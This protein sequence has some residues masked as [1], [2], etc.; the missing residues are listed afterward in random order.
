MSEIN[1]YAIVVLAA[2]TSSRLGRPK[3]LLNIRGT[4][5]LHYIV[6]T[7]L[8]SN[9]FK[10]LVVVGS[11]AGLMRAE[12]EDTD[13]VV[14]TNPEYEEGIASSIRVGISTME[15]EEV[16]GIIFI[17]CDQ[18]YLTSSHLIALAEKQAETGAAIVASEYAGQPGIPALFRR[19]IFAELMKLEGENGA[20]KI[21][22][23][24][25]NQAELVPFHNGEVD[26]DTE[27]AYDA[28]LNAEE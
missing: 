26:I 15:D 6:D 8:A 7:A 10:V 28:F 21:I 23:A 25:G 20:K 11:D 5:L 22:L 4:S 1:K 13:A 17:S 24:H 12:I 14:E 9:P 3:Q 18:P 2:G 19:E 16:E 27:E